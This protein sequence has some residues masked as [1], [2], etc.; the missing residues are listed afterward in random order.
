MSL[1]RVLISAETHLSSDY[2]R[3]VDEVAGDLADLETLVSLGNP[4][5]DAPVAPPERG[6]AS[7]VGRVRPYVGIK[8]IDPET[9]ETVERERDG[10]LCTHGYSVMPGWDDPERTAEA[11]D[12]DG[13]MHTGDLATMDGDGYVNIVGRIKDMIIRGGENVCPREIEGF[14]YGRP[15]VE[16]VHVIGIRDERYGEQIMAWIEPREGTNTTE[17]DIIGYC[18]G[19]IAHL[20]I[21][22]VCEVR[23]R[24]PHDGYEKGPEGRD[25]RGVHRRTRL[26]GGGSHQVRVAAAAS[27]RLAATRCPQMSSGSGR[28]GP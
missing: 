18:E 10:E 9:G 7:T 25:A 19:R 8:I 11:V 26:G 22:Q 2:R 5:R 14:L 20:R 21:P 1:C 16:D 27:A 15:G 12:A 6:T 28:R 4:E 13:W 23:R 3:M 24:I 17:D